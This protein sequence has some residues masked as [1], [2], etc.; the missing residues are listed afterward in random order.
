M[1]YLYLLAAICGYLLGSVSISILLSRLFLHDDVRGHGSGNAGATNVA[2]V[3]GMKAGLIT[4]GG[5]M[6]K[7]LLSAILGLLLA[8]RTGLAIGCAGCLLGHCWPVFFQFRGGKGVSVSTC[9][10]LLLDLRLFLI[11]VAVFFLLFF[12]TR[13][14][15]VCS[16]AAAV[17][18]PVVYWLLYPGFSVTFCLCLLIFVLVLFM[19]RENFCRLL[20]GE[21][22]KFQPKSNGSCNK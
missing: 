21:E 4:L 9:I 19:H 13:R 3:Y 10:A 5:D 12:L 1:T 8:G 6:L 16:M 15:S 18:F 2:R 20:R 14:V 7:T 17:A 11:L 22:P